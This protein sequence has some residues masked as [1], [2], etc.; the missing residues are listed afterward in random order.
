M[1][2]ERVDYPGE[3]LDESA[4]ASTP[5]AQI[6]RWLDAAIERQA[7]AGDVP[8]PVSLSVAT[9]DPH[10]AP[11]VRTVLLRVLDASG[12]GFFTNTES[13]KAREIAANPAV[14]AALTW[15]AM[16]RAVRV[17][18]H[19]EPLPQAAVE[20][21]FRDRPWGSR[22]SAWASRQSRPV[23]DRAALEAAYERFAARFPDQGGRGDVPVPDYWGGYLIRCHEVELWAG[24]RDRLHDRLVF[25]SVTGQV[26]SLGDE[27]AWTVSRRQP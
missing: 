25:T 8:E 27:A 1:S 13:A 14:A 2:T 24:R 4:L 9:V 5:L 20:D 11:N 26:A 6:R 3:G 18:G 17:R 16:F 21:Y 23:G 22:I 10:G 7:T 12:L 19:A 15:P